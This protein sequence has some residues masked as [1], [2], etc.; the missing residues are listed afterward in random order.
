MSS[1]PPCD[2]G[3]IHTVISLA[4]LPSCS[5]PFTALTRPLVRPCWATC[6]LNRLTQLTGH[7]SP[8]LSRP[9]L[10]PSSHAPRRHA[11]WWKWL[12]FGGADMQTCRRAGGLLGG[13]SGWRWGCEGTSGGVREGGSVS[14]LLFRW[15]P[16]CPPSPLVSF[17]KECVITAF[18]GFSSCNGSGGRPC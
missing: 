11:C 15:C 14:A 10:T 6:S 17:H 4:W 9:P 12:V 5:P 8:D 2:E 3:N 7:E 16:A 13:D 18:V 1:R